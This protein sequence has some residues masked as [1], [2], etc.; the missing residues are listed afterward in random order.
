MDALPVI[1]GNEVEA[2][3]F[4]RLFHETYGV[5]SLVVA[6]Y[7]RGHINNSSILSVRYCERHIMEDEEKFVALLNSLAA[8]FADR[9]LI[10]LVNVDE[11]VDVIVRNRHRLASNWFFPFAAP[12]VVDLANS[13]EAMAQVYEKVGEAAPRRAVVHL[14][15]PDTWDAALT[16]LPFPIVVKP[17]RADNPT[18]LYATGLK[19]V[20]V[21]DDAAAA[22]AKFARLAGRQ[23]DIDLIAQ[24]L[25][26]GDDTTQWVVNG[27]IDSRGHLSAIGSGRVLLGLH[28]PSLIGNAGIILTDPD[29]FL[30]DRAERIVRE[31]GLRGFF[32]MDVKIDP[33]T[34]RAY[35]LD[36]NPRAGRGHYYLKVGGVN[37]A[38][39]LVADI[40]GETAPLQRVNRAGIFAIIPAWL[41][42]RNYVRD[43]QL[44]AQVRRVRRRGPVVNPIAY[45]KDRHLKRAI[46]R[47]LSDIRAVQKMRRFYPH[48]TESGF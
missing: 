35:W 5:N 13:K 39:A 32:S 10:C 23:V 12:E 22:R 25:I 3:S 9:T 19:K 47:M 34:G 18:S 15:Q 27:Y 14:S 45:S 16:S 20:E 24:E 42:G 28:E 6:E 31:V 48:P 4:A 37:L 40:A 30:T 8:E 2:Y 33:R 36:L 41:A 11:G 21:F 17:A 29:G 26:P 46:F 44:A 1:F 43:P 38:R 7:P